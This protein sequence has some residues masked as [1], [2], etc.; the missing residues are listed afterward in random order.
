MG[1]GSKPT[2]GFWYHVAYHH[3]LTIGPI[4]AF[5]EMRGGDKTAWQGEL[6]A[7]GTIH[8][9]APQLWGGEKDQGGIVSDV[10]IMFGEPTQLRSPYLVSTFGAQTAAWR[11]FSTVVF[12][13][14]RYGAMNP[15]PQKPAYKFRQILNGWD[16]GCWY[17][18]KAAI[19]YNGLAA[20]YDDLWSY[21]IEAPGSSADYSAAS[22]DD[23]GWDIAPGAFGS[24]T[25]T[26]SGLALNTFVSGGIGKAIWIRRKVNF[27]GSTVIDIYHDDGAWLW[28]NGAAGALTDISYYH[29]QATVMLTG[30]SVIALK[31][32]DG[33][34]AG[35]VNIFAGM[36]FVGGTQSNLAINPAHVLYY[37]RTNNEMGR[38][39]TTTINDASLRAAADQLYAEGFGICPKWDPASETVEDF[40]K[41]ICKLIGGSFSRS[42][43]DGQWYLDLARGDYVL[44]DLPI[45]NDDDIL[46]FKEQPSILDNA[47]NSVSVKYFDPETKQ[48]IVTAPVRALGLVTA[49]GTIHQTN[50]Y[51]EIPAGALGAR[52]A[53]RDLLTT[54][55][56]TRAFDLATTRKPYN[57]RPNQYFRLQSPKRG[58]ADMVCIVG[59]L[60]SGTLKSGAIKLKATQDIYSLPGTSFVNVEAGVDTRPSQIATPLT[61]QRVFEAPYIKVVGA[62]SR[63]ELDALPDDAGYVIAVAITPTSDVDYT[64]M[65]SAGGDYAEAASGNWCS[66]ATVTGASNQSALALTLAN[67]SRLDMVVVGMGALWDDEIV[68]VDAI[69]AVAGTITLCRGCA[70][71]VPALHA[72]GSRLWFYDT[73]SANNTTEYIA[74]E[75]INVKLL[76]NT[77]SQR[78]SLASA[79]AL[80]LTFASRQIRPYAPGALQ[81]NAASYPTTVSGSFTVTWAHRNRVTQADQLVDTSTASITPE[82]NT[83]YALRLL[84]S[85]GAL[86][87][88]QTNIGP[89]TA[90]VVLNYTGNV[91]LELYTIDDANISWQRHSVTFAYTPPAG[92]VVTTITAT[93]YTPVYDGIIVDGGA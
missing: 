58:I 37:S 40:E 46:D 89:P 92:T 17:P 55:T 13:G 24:G 51:P 20:P 84:D 59:E 63:T 67:L 33:V 66:T 93:P 26:G 79:T 22:Y 27:V 62:M 42:L 74:A 75:A 5:L 28:I 72:D 53:L 6:T 15:Y 88:E 36:T 31:V 38:E 9:N 12:K 85:T 82:P 35:S 19:V 7:S 56:P 65:V 43:E 70:D 86:L 81:I 41:R 73:G 68:R 30:A 71:T 23:S 48:T 83:R 78:L 14:G 54:S 16:A 18:E 21:H 50:E 2:V 4:D 39:S 45:L 29:A 11:G 64:M 61:L 8:I 32:M 91:T 3:G 44:A 87:V 76:S 10:D 34:P 60:S 49:F 90:D 69:D 52:V 77:G 25:P 80:P 57:W 1:K 47:I